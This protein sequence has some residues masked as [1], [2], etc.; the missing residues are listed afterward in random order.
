[1]IAEAGVTRDLFPAPEMIGNE[2]GD[3]W[4]WLVEGE[5]DCIWLWSIGLVG[6]AVPGAQNWRSEWG[7]RLDSPFKIAVCFDADP[8]GQT[9]AMRAAQDLAFRG[10]NVRIV[11]LAEFHQRTGATLNG[12]VQ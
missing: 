10:I 7:E 9:G 11:S 8:A 6:I 1:M 5:P 3:G 12:R 2:E 4:R